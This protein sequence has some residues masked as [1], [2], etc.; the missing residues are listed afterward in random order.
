MIDMKKISGWMRLWIVLSI[1]FIIPTSFFGI[2]ERNLTYSDYYISHLETCKDDIKY[3]KDEKEYRIR[4]DQCVVE[5]NNK[6]DEYM[7]NGNSLSTFI[8]VFSVLP[9]MLIWILGFISHQ[10]YKWIKKGFKE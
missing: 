3:I 8:G 1:L 7:K 4:Y 9:L 6:T 5:V 2:R 10:V